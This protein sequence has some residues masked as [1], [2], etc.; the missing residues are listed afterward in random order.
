MHSQRRGG[1]TILA[2]ALVC[3]CLVLAGCA[4][5][6]RGDGSAAGGAA[7]ALTT[8]Q[9]RLWLNDYVRRFADEVARTADGIQA[10]TSDDA[11]VRAALAW[12]LGAIPAAY[13][14]GTLEDA[15][16]ALGDLWAL[17]LQMEALFLTEPPRDSLGAERAAAASCARRMR[18]EFEDLARRVSPTAA[19]F[20]EARALVGAF[21]AREPLTDLTFSRRSV[22]PSYLA[23]RAGEKAAFFQAVENLG[24][25]LSAMQEMIVA[26]AAQL[27]AMVRWQAELMLL[28]L[29]RNRRIGRTLADFDGMDDSLK[30]L[31]AAS[32]RATELVTAQSTEI[33]TTL[34]G[35]RVATFA[36]I[37]GLR[38]RSF[39]AL[40]AQRD[41]TFAAV[42]AEREATVNALARERQ[43]LLGDVEALAREATDRSMREARG[44]V[45][46]ALARALVLVA[47]LTI[48]GIVL[49]LTWRLTPRRRD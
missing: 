26:Y 16:A 43:T 45:D 4:T 41:A 38:A 49:I 37:E 24:D 48:A 5:M 46:H 18:E 29:P 30:R 25:N 23:A 13:R 47:A 17:T 36:E 19:A 20:E 15:Q 10:R 42:A 32:D 40:D 12:K 35:E 21:A 44:L 7:T 34:R 3:A 33:L 39:A 8:R 11:V 6:P 22:V 27:P 14:A 28:D 31:A 2:T 9:T 1:T